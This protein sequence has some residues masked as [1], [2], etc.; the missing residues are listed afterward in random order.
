MLFIEADKERCDFLERKIQTI[1]IPSN[2]KTIC[3]CAKFDEKLIEIL[4][5]I[6]IQ[7]YNQKL[8]LR[9]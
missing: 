6:D 3:E 7:S 1:K 5:I 2:I 9:D 4:E 8:C